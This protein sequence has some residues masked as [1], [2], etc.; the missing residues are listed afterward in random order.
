MS[1]G[2]GA[3]YLRCV[4][5]RLPAVPMLLY[6]LVIYLLTPVLVLR[7]FARSRREPD[8]RAGWWRR[9]AIRQETPTVE[10]SRRIWFHAVS[11]GEVLA[12]APIVE[13]LIAQRD[14]ALLVTTTTATGARE[15]RRVFG[16]RVDHAWAPI[17]A[18][19]VVRRFLN[20]WRPELVALVETEVWPNIVTEAKGRA[21]PVLLVNARMSKR[22]ARGYARFGCVFSRVFNV[23]DGV[24][25]HGRADAR[26]LVALGV[27]P[28]AV[29]M[30]ESVKFEIDIKSRRD[31]GAVIA[32]ELAMPVDRPVVV[33]GSIHPEEQ[34]TLLDAMDL[35]WPT[36]PTVL[37]VIAPRHLHSVK[38]LTQ[39]L[40]DRGVDY[41]LRSQAESRISNATR[42]V[43]LDTFGELGS[44]YALALTAIIGGT[45]F[46]RGGHNPLEAIALGVPVIAGHSTF[47]F[48]HIYKELVEVGSCQL[49][50]NSASLAAAVMHHL[51]DTQNR[52]QAA[53][54][55]QHYFSARAGAARK[56]VELITSF[57]SAPTR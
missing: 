19:L 55:G 43:V 13:Q 18:G 15:A 34:L 9:L 6:S 42:V 41:V 4:A 7:V 33:A 30:V 12:V 25:C 23:L 46:D 1:C 51:V 31:K 27:K 37:F 38:A 48:A 54:A 20:H 36:L 21:I 16:A 26:R 10:G 8:Y 47:N 24:I 40:T 5:T 39:A 44:V 45:L 22:S 50:A 3:I 29:A 52:E 35:V 32:E 49:V 57:V 53:S 17:D 56:Q 28:S 14:C 2:R 11:V